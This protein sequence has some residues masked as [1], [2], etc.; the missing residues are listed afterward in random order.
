MING[1]YYRLGEAANPAWERRRQ[2]KAEF[3]ERIDFTLL[4]K[5][6]YGHSLP[7]EL[8]ADMVRSDKPGQGFA[9]VPET[10]VHANGFARFAGRSEHLGPISSEADFCSRLIKVK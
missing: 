1:G 4:D 3:L 9:L 8:V 5:G 10:S 2:D 7:F 6:W